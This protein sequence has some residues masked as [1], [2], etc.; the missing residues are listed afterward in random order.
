MNQLEQID[1]G[2]EY[3]F[4]F[5]DSTETT[6]TKVAAFFLNTIIGISIIVFFVAAFFFTTSSYVETTIVRN[7]TKE[8]VND[9]FQ[10]LNT[11]LN[12]SQRIELTNVIKKHL[13][14]DNLNQDKDIDEQNHKLIFNTM[15]VL[16][17]ILFFGLLLA[18]F[19]WYIMKQKSPR[20]KAGKNYPDVALLL[21]ENSWL[22]VFVA[23]TKI[24]FLITISTKYRKVDP[25]MVKGNIISSILEFLG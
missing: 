2:G 1:L 6:Q 5:D 11:F 12:P 10:D 21:I 7:D 8:L 16:I 20:D 24:V 14:S 25:A 15:I 18:N 17:S 13:V 9:M 4:S 23:L 22:L 19:V 3:P